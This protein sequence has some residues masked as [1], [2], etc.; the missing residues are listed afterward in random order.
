VFVCAPTANVV[1]DSE[2]ELPPCGVKTAAGGGATVSGKRQVTV[3]NFRRAAFAAEDSNKE[4][5]GGKITDPQNKSYRHCFLMRIRRCRRP[6][7]VFPS[8]LT[9]WT[10]KFVGLPKVPSRCSRA[11]RPPEPHRHS[12]PLQNQVKFAVAIEVD[13]RGR[14]NIK[15][16]TRARA[17]QKGSSRA[18][19]S[20]TL[21]EEVGLVACDPD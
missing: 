14:V 3:S 12:V 13:K 17:N 18:E 21:V 10:M 20:S 8:R 2:A 6:G 7:P 15:V 19:G 4:T 11:H 5:Q 16:H 9:S 1:S